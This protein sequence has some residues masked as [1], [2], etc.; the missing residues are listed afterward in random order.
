M[1]QESGEYR[2]SM[3]LSKTLKPLLLLFGVLLFFIHCSNDTPVSSRFDDLIGKNEVGQV[4]QAALQPPQI[5]STAGRIIN[6]GNSPLLYLG[7]SNNLKSSFL[8][9]FD[10]PADV[11]VRA[12]ELLLPTKRVVGD[13]ADFEAT[14]HR[15][16]SDWL[17][18][19]DG[20]NK[21]VTYDN[22]NNAF[23]AT[24][25]GTQTV[26][27]ADSD[28]VLI[29]LDAVLVGGW[30][31]SSI[32]NYG[33]LV[34]APTATFAKQFHSRNSTAAQPLLRLA[35]TKNNADSTTDIKASRD[36][37]IF[38]VLRPPAPGPL[39]VSQGTYYRALVKFDLSAFPPGAAGNQ[40]AAT[41]NRAQ[42]IFTID[43]ANSHLIS[44]GM[45]VVLLNV[46]KNSSDP[47][48]A[49]EDSTGLVGQLTV[50]DDSAAVT[51]EIRALVQG[52]LRASSDPNRLNN[53][54]VVVTALSPS[55]DLQQ[56]GLH[57]K[58][59]NPALAPTLK[60]DYTLPPSVK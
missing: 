12:A 36:A 33:V 5:D 9:R 60:I 15:V 14:A 13:G 56:L 20:D 43:R 22:F 48:A 30:S 42:L 34:Q 46:G 11:A 31:D 16:T 27:S 53:F 50:A 38:E 37:F 17:E 39:Y 24:I 1:N 2:S 21:G 45:S 40:K 28:T 47:I 58:E 57:S 49:V 4:Q 54:G 10:V 26:S 51:F 44:E 25:A 23:D 35:Y 52:W 8:I 19:D 6:T 55:V 41:I 29:N 32:A 7:T 18:V 59:S 3:K